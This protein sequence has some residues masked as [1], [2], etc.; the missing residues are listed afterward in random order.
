M[1]E[2]TNQV[3]LFTAFLRSQLRRSPRTCAEYSKDLQ[4]FIHWSESY[5]TPLPIDAVSEPI[6]NAWVA[7]MAQAN[8]SAATIRR[9]VSCVRSF[10][11]WLSLHLS[12]EINPAQRIQ[13]PRIAPR[14]VR[15]AD[16]SVVRDFINGEPRTDF[17]LQVRFVVI[18]MY[19]CGLRLSE[20]LALRGSDIDFTRCVVHIIGK[21]NRERFCAFDASFLPHIMDFV[22]GSTDPLFDNPNEATFRWAIIRAVRIQG[23]GVH[24]HQIRHLYACRCLENGMPLKTLS[25]LLGHASIKTTERYL[26]IDRRAL[27]DASAMYAPV[28]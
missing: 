17:Q 4:Y 13:T 12:R 5:L 19:A 23:R 9:R 16:E 14:L 20:V 7:S 1:I 24:P 27:A 18:M 15:P 10:Y 25:L 3:S 26:N 28:L 11:R 22:G 8:L 2:V 6:V 21:G